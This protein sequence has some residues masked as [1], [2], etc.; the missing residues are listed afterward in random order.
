RNVSQV[1][2]ANPPCF[3][4]SG[5]SRRGTSGRKPH[6]MPHPASVMELLWN[7]CSE[8]VFLVLRNGLHIVTANPRLAEV[9]GRDVV[10]EE[11]T[12]LTQA[13]TG[14]LA[15]PGPHEDAPL[16][17]LDAYPVY[18]QLTVTHFDH[19]GEP[20]AACIARDTTEKRHLERELVVKHTAL[21][22]AHGE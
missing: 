20:Y 14:V 2:S 9:V 11:S 16:T 15:H 1:L 6:R 12:A 4:D 3:P 5:P 10:G 19:E 22:S 17:C 8:A 13:A 18:V 7:Q 21:W